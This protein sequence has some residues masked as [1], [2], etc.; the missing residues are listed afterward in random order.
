M[1]KKGKKKTT[2]IDSTEDLE[3]KSVAYF[4]N[5]SQVIL[6]IVLIVLF[7]F[8]FYCTLVYIGDYYKEQKS[9]YPENEVFKINNDKNSVLI[10]N[11]GKIEKT[12]AEEDTLLKD[13]VVIEN[14]SSIELSTNKDAEM[15]G[16]MVYDLRYNI[17]KNDFK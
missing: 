5:S 17:T 4:K 2:K 1:N 9:E 3:I 6:L 15:N 14:Y 11:N 16:T 7:G 12:I 8:T 13:N 10:I